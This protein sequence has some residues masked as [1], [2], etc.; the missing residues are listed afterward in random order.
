MVRAVYAA[1]YPADPAF[2]TEDI[3]AFL[4]AHPEIAALNRARRRNE[5]LERSLA[6]D[7]AKP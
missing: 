4:A 6:Q 3:L 7:A 1:L 2:G 5:G